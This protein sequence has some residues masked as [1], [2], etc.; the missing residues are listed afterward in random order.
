MDPRWGHWL[1]RLF[2]LSGVER[3]HVYAACEYDA[4]VTISLL[5]GLSLDLEG[6]S[7]D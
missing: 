6:L 3:V 4:W 7:R 2:T 1:F 5:R